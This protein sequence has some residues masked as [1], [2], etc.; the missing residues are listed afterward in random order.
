MQDLGVLNGSPNSTAQAANVDGS[1]VVGTSSGTAF[2]WTS[3]LGMVNL[4]TY[5]PSRGINLAGWTL[6]DAYGISADG[7][8]IV[9]TGNHNPRPEGWVVHLGPVCRAD[10]NNSGTTNSQDFFDFLTCFFAGCP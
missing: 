3:S 10:F 9:G 2:L 4:N 6:F 5:L 7:Q 8:T 1:V